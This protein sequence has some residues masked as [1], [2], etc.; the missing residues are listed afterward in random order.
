M[1]PNFDKYIGIPFEHKGRGLS[2]CDCYGLVRLVFENERKI[3]LPDFLDIDYSCGLE[4]NETYIQDEY[5]Q[6]LSNGWVSIDKPYTLWDCFIFYSNMEKGIADHIGIC[7]DGDKFLHASCA[8]G[9]VL[10][11][12]LDQYWI[13]KIYDVARWVGELDG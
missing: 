4:K 8:V 11:S 2:G 13:S 10:V 3:G 6:F 9:S 1:K 5:S 7:I 12:R